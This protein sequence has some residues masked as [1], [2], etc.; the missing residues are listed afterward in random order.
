MSAGIQFKPL[1][2]DLYSIPK[3]QILFK[4][5][6]NDAFELLGDADDVTITINVDETERFTNEA[7]IQQ[8][9]KA[10]V[11]KVDAVLG[12][13]LVQLSDRNRA[14]SLLGELD[15]EVQTAD[16]AAVVNILNVEIDD[17]IYQLDHFN[18][19]SIT[20]V[21]DGVTLETYI[22]DV[23]YKVDLSGGFMQFIGQPAGADPDVIITY[24]APEVLSSDEVSKIGIA[25]KT[26]NRGTLVIRG[27]NEV[28]PRSLVQLHDVQLRP[29]GE[30]NYVSDVDLDTI[31]VVGRIF[32]DDSQPEGFEL[33]FERELL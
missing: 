9:A 14:L 15:F 8:L 12:L 5:L 25:N 32:R 27:T 20:S 26:E 1:S 11:T 30:R 4:P 33:G 22:A 19:T 16:A 31:E 29:D 2:S 17:K 10:I 18:I 6:G 23:H 28:G 3:A 7:G 13:T 21:T 24:N